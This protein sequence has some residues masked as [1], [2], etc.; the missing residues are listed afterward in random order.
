MRAGTY[1]FLNKVNGATTSVKIEDATP[2]KIKAAFDIA[3]TSLNPGNRDALFGYDP[4]GVEMRYTS[5]AQG[6]K[7]D[8]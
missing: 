8:R 3:N 7:F 4:R 2:S 6:K 1:K 5:A